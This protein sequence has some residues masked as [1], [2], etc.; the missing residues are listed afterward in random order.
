MV[1]DRTLT[2]PIAN[3]ALG[4]SSVVQCTTPDAPMRH[5]QVMGAVD[6]CGAVFLHATPT[7]FGGE[8]GWV[9]AVSQIR[10]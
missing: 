3:A 2:N 8:G 6:M 4:T 10:Y 1:G 5:Q 9:V 7:T